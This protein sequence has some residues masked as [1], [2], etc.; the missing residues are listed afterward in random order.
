MK[1][2]SMLIT[3]GWIVGWCTL[4]NLAHAQTAEDVERAKA[5]VNLEPVVRDIVR[6]ALKHFRATPEDLD[7][8]RSSAR[9]RGFLPLLAGGFRYDSIRTNRNLAQSGTTVITDYSD[10]SGSNNNSFTLGAVWDFREL[11]MNPVE[12]QTYGIIGVQRDIMLECARVFY[13]RRQIVLKL[14]LR[15]SEDPVQN[16][17]NEVRVQELT[18]I[19]DIM[20]DGWFSREHQRRLRSARQVNASQPGPMMDKKISAG[21]HSK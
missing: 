1:V 15:P 6:A 3:A 2:R 16:L 13:L 10:L 5:Q 20:T 21:V 17:A 19:L 18:A 11:M 7:K 14:L 9:A 4:S 12:I 8:L